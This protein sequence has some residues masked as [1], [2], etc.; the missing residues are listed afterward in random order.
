MRYLGVY[1]AETGIT[2]SCKDGVNSTLEVKCKVP[3]SGVFLRWCETFRS[4]LNITFQKGEGGIASDSKGKGTVPKV[5]KKME[6]R[7]LIEHGSFKNLSI[8]RIA[9]KPT[10]RERAKRHG[11]EK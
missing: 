5:G 6:G 2:L 3:K 9:L 11:V 4:T 7:S 10:K 1:R 8:C